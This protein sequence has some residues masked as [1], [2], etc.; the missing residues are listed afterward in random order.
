MNTTDVRLLRQCVVI[1]GAGAV[2]GMFVRLLTGSGARVVVA[3]PAGG[4]VTDD[5]GAPG[6]AL[7]AELR[8]ADLVVL[9]L[10]ERAA[11]TALPRVAAHL[12][13]GA[14]VV[15]TL[16][17]KRQVVAALSAT[18][19]IEAVSLNPMFAPSLGMPGN[20]VAAV[21]VH[22]GEAASELLR[23]LAG[24]GGRE[25]RVDADEHDRLTAAA[26][27][28]THASVLGF[29]LGLAELG[30]NAGELAAIA[31]PPHTTLLA[32]LS[33]I[34]SGSPEVYWDV[35][36]AHPHAAGART[37]LASGLR[38]LADLVERGDEAGFGAALDDVRDFLGGELAPHAEICAQLFAG[39]PQRSR[40]EAT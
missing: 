30:V 29:G 36:A 9:A 4:E 23:L 40:N 7:V 16:S 13:P 26:Q 20:P 25:V 28:L 5:A 14:L 31:P 21:V 33:R 17:V 37:A 10:P 1:G 12:R 19:G 6:P 3:D 2:G 32:L 38:R 34:A 35:Q 18:P 39:L 11:L 27:V 8:R 15:D 24:W 22:D